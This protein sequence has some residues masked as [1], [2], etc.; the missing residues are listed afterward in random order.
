[1]RRREFVT[2]AISGSGSA[3]M[4]GCSGVGQEGGS[5]SGDDGTVAETPTSEPTSTLQPAEVVSELNVEAAAFV[6]TA[7]DGLTFGVG[8]TVGNSTDSSPTLRIEAALVEAVDGR[9]IVSRAV[10][11]QIPAGTEGT[12]ELG[13]AD[14]TRMSWQQLVATHFEPFRFRLTVA[15]V[16]QQIGCPEIEHAA[17]E[18]D[19]CLLP[20]GLVRTVV[21]VDCNGPWD[22]I[23]G[24]DGD[25]K[26]V[27]RGTI[28]FGAPEEYER[29]YVPIP[30]DAEFVSAGARKQETSPGGLA[31][32][33]RHRGEVL[34][35][36][37][38]ASQFNRVDVNAE[39]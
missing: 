9:D 38:T 6:D 10:E 5:T 23:V 36:A 34:D 27:A 39:V 19:G 16:T 24:V 8:G 12:L 31:V 37:T 1:M 25:P 18:D 11:R 14:T 32:R 33:I 35:E 7:G 13:I 17:A 4:A 26:S 28:Q 20:F 3:V 21:E 2:A 29:S 22:G 30:N 15:G